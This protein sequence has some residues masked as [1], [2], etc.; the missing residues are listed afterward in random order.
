MT[1]HSTHNHWRPKSYPAQTCNECASRDGST[2]SSPVPE[3]QE[4]IPT[5]DTIHAVTDSSAVVEG[6]TL[7]ICLDGTGDKFDNDNSNVVN[8]VACLKKD[9]PRQITYYQSGIGTYDGQGMKNGMS[10]V[11]DM[12]IYSLEL[13]YF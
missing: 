9:D 6:R 10:A 4:P 2:L 13:Q 5:P 8:F 7:I 12:V 3:E 1:D 11:V